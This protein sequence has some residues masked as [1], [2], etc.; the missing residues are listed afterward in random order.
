[1]IVE[2]VDSDGDGD[3]DV[4]SLRQRQ[5]GAERSPRR[6]EIDTHVAPHCR[7]EIV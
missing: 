4:F 6:P 5:R 1:V 2:V 7:L 3:D